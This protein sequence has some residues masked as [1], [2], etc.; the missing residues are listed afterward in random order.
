MRWMLILI[1][2]CLVLSVASIPAWSEGGVQSKVQLVP[3]VVE[4]NIDCLI[5]P[6]YPNGE[7]CV[8]TITFDEMEITGSI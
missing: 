1:A 4:N 8:Q 6:K 3:D 2:V 7:V 5:A